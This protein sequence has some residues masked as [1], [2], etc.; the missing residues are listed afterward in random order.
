M[1]GHHQGTDF[2]ILVTDVTLVFFL[3]VFRHTGVCLPGLSGQPLHV[4]DQPE[5]LSGLL[6]AS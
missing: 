1:L 2:S 4:V 3:V 6:G 5:L